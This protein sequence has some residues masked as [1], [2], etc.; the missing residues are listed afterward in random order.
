MTAKDSISPNSV[1]ALIIGGNKTGLNAPITPQIATRMLWL[2]VKEGNGI[3][4]NG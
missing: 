1:S 4:S 3:P 2:L